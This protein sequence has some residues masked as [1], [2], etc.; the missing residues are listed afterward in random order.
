MQLKGLCWLCC[1]WFAF[2]KFYSIFLLFNFEVIKI[3]IYW[4][5]GFILLIKFNGVTERAIVDDFIVEPSCLI[6]W[7]WIRHR[8]ATII[9]DAWI[10]KLHFLISIYSF[11]SFIWFYFLIDPHHNLF[12]EFFFISFNMHQNYSYYTPVYTR[13]YQWIFKSINLCLD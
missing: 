12:Y 9:D 2:W 7:R 10:G 4:L 8:H 11:K 6:I 5:Y 13:K 1:V 3:L